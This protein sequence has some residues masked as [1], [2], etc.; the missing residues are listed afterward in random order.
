MNWKYTLFLL[1]TLLFLVGCGQE[2]GGPEEIPV[3]EATA[4][5]DDTEPTPTPMPTGV[6]ILA[7]G[8][9]KSSQPLLPLAFETSGKLLE[10]YVEPGVYVTEG[11]LVARLDD[12]ALQEAVINAQLQVAQAENSLA[13]A[14]AELDRLLAWQ[15]DALAVAQ[16]E[17]NLAAAQAAL[18]N[19]QLSDSAAGNS[20]TS[21]SVTVDQAE[22][23]VADAQKAYDTAHDPGRDWELNDP[24]RA[25]FLKAERDG[26]ARNLEFA[27][28]QLRVAQ[29][30]Y[31][32]AAA[33]VNN[34][35]AVSAAA[36]V[37]A[38]E[39]ALAQTQKG[40]TDA[41]ITLAQLRVEQAQIALEQSQFNEQQAQNALSKAELRAT[42]QGFIVRL[43]ATEGT[44]VG[45]GT[46]ILTLM[47]AF[48]ME[49]HTTNLSERD[50]AQIVPDAPVIITLKAYPDMP[51]EGFVRQIGF[52][53]EGSVGDAA[54]FP[55][56]ISL[57]GYD[58][59]GYQIREGMTGRAEIRRLEP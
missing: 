1:G 47:P 35:T 48:S 26:T 49:F 39:Q 8:V 3:A 46:P 40:P 5:T 33:G 51:I 30:N 34:D 15:P 28:E 13:Q 42:G 54:T 20:L 9:V 12:T 36:N 18:E 2:M 58:T 31:A 50:L 19:A 17:A 44:L 23:A 56:I 45:S 43:D 4:V 37:A 21:A 52:Q 55:V 25:D 24:W 57:G 59:S 14:Q 7:D 32:L 29:A 6:T 41:E 16:A 11:S 22:R 10:V 27:Q 38:A 53:A